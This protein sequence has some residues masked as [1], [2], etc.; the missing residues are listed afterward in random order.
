MRDAGRAVCLPKYEMFA[1]TSTTRSGGQAER[2]VQKLVTQGT[3]GAATDLAN[4]LPVTV[5]SNPPRA[6]FTR[7]DRARNQLLRR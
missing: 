2:V 4:R 7:A 1:L 3:L 6:S 5:V